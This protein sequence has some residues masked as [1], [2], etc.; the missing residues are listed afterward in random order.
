MEP[1]P[2]VYLPREV[3]ALLRCDVRTVRRMVERGE[4]AGIRIGSDLRVTRKSVEALLSSAPLAARVLE[5]PKAS[6]STPAPP[7]AKAKARKAKSGKA[8]AK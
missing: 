8:R 5:P 1:E 2:A 4:L 7:R 3:A 6:T